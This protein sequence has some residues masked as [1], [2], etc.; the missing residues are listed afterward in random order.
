MARLCLP[1]ASLLLLVLLIGCGGDGKSGTL[2]VNPGDQPTKTGGPPGQTG[3]GGTG[4]ETGSAEQ[5]A[6]AGGPLDFNRPIHLVGTKPSAIVGLAYSPDGNHLASISSG[7][8]V[9]LWDLAKRSRTVLAAGGSPNTGGEGSLAPFNQHVVFSPDGKML[10][11]G[12]VAA[13]TQWEVESGKSVRT[14]SHTKV[15]GYTNGMVVAPDGKTVVTYGGDGEGG[16]ELEGVGRRCEGGHLQCAA[17]LGRALA[18][19]ARLPDTGG[20]TPDAERRRSQD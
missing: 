4:G 1:V 9:V 17:S 7:G 14:F 16:R 6:Q 12:T 13:V 5:K 11:F 2:A 3:G 15:E 10:F 18:L 8:E 20:D 19:F